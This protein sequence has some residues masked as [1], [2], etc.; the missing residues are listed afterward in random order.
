MGALGEGLA[1]PVEVGEEEGRRE[2][3]ASALVLS[4]KAGLPEPPALAVPRGG[5]GEAEALR[6]EGLAVPVEVGEEE[7]R[8]EAVAGALALALAQHVGVR[9]WLPVPAPALAVAGPV[10][11]GDCEAAAV[12]VGRGVPEGAGVP[13]AGLGEA[14]PVVQAEG[15]REGVAVGVGR[16]EVEERR[17]WVLGRGWG[18][19]WGWGRGGGMAWGGERWRPRQ[20]PW[21]WWRG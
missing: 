2:A 12:P 4:V 1:V 19:G 16:E 21:V 17:V 3:V 6:G 14:L 13:V 20:R 11:G 18:R 10:A 5:E 7:G 15:R 8:R 9:R